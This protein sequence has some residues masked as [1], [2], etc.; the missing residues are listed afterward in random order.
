MLIHSC[1]KTIVQ[2]KSETKETYHIDHQIM[3]Q[4]KSEWVESL[5]AG[6]GI[7]PQ[8]TNTHLRRAQKI[9][10]V[11]KTTMT[12]TNVTIDCNIFSHRY[13]TL[14]IPTLQTFSVK[15]SIFALSYFQFPTTSDF[16]TFAQ[17]RFVFCFRSPTNLNYITGAKISFSHRLAGVIKYRATRVA[18]NKRDGVGG[19]LE[20]VTS[21]ANLF[22][23]SLTA[24]QPLNL[25]KKVTQA[26]LRSSRTWILSHYLEI[27]FAERSNE[28][29]QSASLSD[30]KIQSATQPL[31]LRK[32]VTQAYL[33]SSQTVEHESLLSHHLEI[34]W[35]KKFKSPIHQLESVSDSKIQITSQPIKLWKIVI[36]W[37]YDALEEFAETGRGK[38]RWMKPHLDKGYK[39]HAFLAMSQF[40][41]SSWK[42]YLEY[43]KQ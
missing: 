36:C 17:I 8:S 35:E 22:P 25:P 27:R 11:F 41:R 6:R 4:R 21:A 3:L 23:I 19:K 10:I 30:N 32:K 20:L 12:T 16:S 5:G 43:V 28:N 38:W 13:P 31:N 15:T 40:L 39:L 18:K 26:Y 42:N 34:G 14:E 29:H 7:N 2:S 33:P 1:W 24:T 37:Y 9:E